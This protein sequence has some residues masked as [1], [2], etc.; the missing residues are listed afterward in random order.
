MRAREGR[1]ENSRT[2]VRDIYLRPCVPRKEEVDSFFVPYT[3]VLPTVIRRYFPDV[4]IT[5]ST[6]KKSGEGNLGKDADTAQ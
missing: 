5:L 1:G 3:D 6:R 2:R 4:A